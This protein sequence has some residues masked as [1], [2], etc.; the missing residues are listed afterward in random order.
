MTFIFRNRKATPTRDESTRE[1][2]A[3]LSAARL[4]PPESVS[5]TIWVAAADY[6]GFRYSFDKCRGALPEYAQV[7]FKR[8]QSEFSVCIFRHKL[9]VKKLTKN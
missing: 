2:E 3:W 9:T 1:I 8:Q 5:M 4:N 6:G 7:H